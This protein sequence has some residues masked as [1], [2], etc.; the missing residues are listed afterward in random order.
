[1]KNL[2]QV[3]VAKPGLALGWELMELNPAPL[4][5]C[6][7]FR[8]KQETAEIIPFLGVW[9]VSSMGCSDITIKIITF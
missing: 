4:G 8:K 5:M 6:A 3:E 2:G 9:R 7:G 1:M